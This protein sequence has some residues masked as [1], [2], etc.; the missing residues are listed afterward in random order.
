[1]THS[2]PDVITGRGVEE[3][4]RQMPIAVIVVAAASGRIVH[5]NEAARAMME[6]Q[7][8]RVIPEE[9][10]ADWQIFHPDGSPYRTEEW[11]VVRSITAGEKVIDEEYSN[12]LP[13]GE[14]MTVRCSA[15]P[16]YDA[17]GAILAG[18][19]VMDDITEQKRVEDELRHHAGLVENT[20]DAVIATDERFRVTAWNRGAETL[21]GWTADE[22]LGADVRQIA[23]S[24]LSD[25]ERAE[26]LRTLLETGRSRAELTPSRKDGT[27]VDVEA[28][29]VAIRGGRGDITGF[30]GIHR[31]ISERKRAERALREAQRRNETILESISDDF[32]SVDREWRCTYVNDRALAQAR[33]A[34]GRDIT[35]E[36]LFGMSIWELLPQHVGTAFH[37][38]LHRAVRERRPVEF[39][40]YSE[41][42][43]RWL[44]VR[45][46]PSDD[47][48]S[49]YSHDISERKR[50]EEAL[51][52]AQ[53]RSE[54]ILESITDAFVAVDR[55]WRYTYVNDRAL[56]R[57][58]SRSGKAFTREDVL[59][60]RVWELFPEVVGTEIHEKYQE[61][62]REQ[63]PVECE[64]YFPPSGE[65]IDA[66]A[67]PS[68]SGL[69]IYYRDVSRR[70]RAEQE[71][72]TRT[73]QEALVAELGRRAP[74]SDG[75]QSLMDDAVALVAR[76]LDVELAGVAEIS[77]GDGG[78][79]VLRAGVGWRE[80][81]V[82][83]RVEDGGR[84]SQVGYTLL[85]GE[86]VVSAD[87]AADER[88]EPS[89]LAQAHGVVSALTVMIAG[90]D[91]PFGVLGA[92]CTGRRDFPPSDVSFVQSVATVLASAVERR[93]AQERLA[94]VRETERRRIA[95]DLHDQAL[96]ELTDA[97][98][99]AGRV[100]AACPEPE[101]ADGLVTALKHVGEHLRGA[102]YGLR[103]GGDEDRPFPEL[104]EA[105]VEVH[106][107]MAVDCDVELDLFQG[108]P[109]RTL[110][111]T[112]T[113]LL[114]VLGEALTNARRHSGA[115]HV[116]IRASGSE[117]G[118]CAEVSDDGR[119]F[120][121]AAGSA[122]VEGSGIRGMRER[123]GLI[124]GE[125]DIRSEPDVGTTVRIHVPLTE[126]GEAPAQPVRVL[127][128]ED[129]ASVRQAI[130]SAFEREAGFEVVGEAGSLAEARELLDDVDADVAVLDLGLPDGYGADLIP[131]LREVNRR[132]QALVLS[133]THDRAEI[134]RAV[135]SGAAGVL[136]K[137]ADLD[138]VVDAVRRLRSGQTLLPLDEVVDLLDFAGRQRERE[139]DERQTL[140][141][142]TAREREILQALADGLDTQRIADRL[143]ISIHTARNHI[144]NILAKLRVHS[145]LQ[146]LV[147]AL[148]YEIVE[149]PKGL[150]LRGP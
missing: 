57:M 47:G 30:L 91:E 77:P 14:R 70:K 124:G 29:N 127:L 129:H 99:Y 146:A 93:R 138:E 98:V 63:R 144:N 66:H 150:Q 134:A 65:W 39:E 12:V 7:L 110:G 76:T 116:R 40:A 106:S 27:P 59:G 17:D 21:Y 69:S 16:I 72:D 90:P 56:R 10:T 5:V 48:L 24:D 123:A 9:L 68:E 49:A 36:E 71:R 73:R 130:A 15:S 19:L 86:P 38:E 145:Q 114:R 52:E 139:N 96:Q 28:I 85:R 82:G 97:L 81:V 61:A 109:T 118:L 42:T 119:G 101:L 83:S 140:A 64:L 6:R 137:M 4:V 11:P 126:D 53:R 44:E 62:M 67:Y 136:S 22:V 111:A 34:A 115:R 128:V 105:L 113:E 32:F 89:A 104:L 132:A 35:R 102:I 78:A 125:L 147:L 135:Q 55:E 121:P 18:V 54:T 26:A 43:G 46:Y 3:V 33:R 117:R 58:G 25:A 37:R 41:P 100:R 103:V 142:L 2:S 149:I 75:L 94:E 51:R 20:A 13:D 60:Q 79:A 143:Q 84:D 50:A 131:E 45:V 1:V 8:D 112:G 95:R 133:A 122:A 88:F 87:Q 120:D 31:D 107:A 80:G 74:A 108:V 23:Q 148:R 92:L 141:E